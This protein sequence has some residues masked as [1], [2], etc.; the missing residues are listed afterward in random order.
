[1]KEKI[2]EISSH[3]FSSLPVVTRQKG[4]LTALNTFFD[5]YH[6]NS[7]FD[8][9]SKNAIGKFINVSLGNIIKD[10]ETKYV[11]QDPGYP[12]VGS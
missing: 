5:Q 11:I 10:Q 2:L 4:G 12:E 8:S 1:M 9:R 7:G 6:P 3:C